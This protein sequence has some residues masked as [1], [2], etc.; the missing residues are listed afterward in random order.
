[1]QPVA[2]APFYAMPREYQIAAIPAGLV[3]DSNGQCK[4]AEG[5]LI[6]GLFAAG[7]CSGPFYSATDYSL[8]TMGLSVGRCITFGY[9]TGGYVAGL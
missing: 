7:N 4:D 8:S 3:I 1:M 2:E 5:D 6:P 9:I